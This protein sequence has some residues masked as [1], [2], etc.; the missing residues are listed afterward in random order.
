[1][2]AT[3]VNQISCTW[4]HTLDTIFVPGNIGMEAFEKEIC[5]FVK[6]TLGIR[7]I[8][9][10]WWSITFELIIRSENCDQH[11]GKAKAQN[12]VTHLSKTNLWFHPHAKCCNTRNKNVSST[13]SISASGYSLWIGAFHETHCTRLCHLLQQ[14]Q[15]LAPQYAEL[16]EQKQIKHIFKEHLEGQWIAINT[17][18]KAKACQTNSASS[19]L[20]VKKCFP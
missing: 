6:M 13:F 19:T 3:N 4:I 20:I 16:K 18:C 1:M 12:R 14:S 10:F 11:M 8:Q 9:V 2:A 5:L 15:P 17:V 7:Y